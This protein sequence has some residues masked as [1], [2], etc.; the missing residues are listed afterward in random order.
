MKLRQL[1]S[2][3]AVRSLHD[4]KV[5]PYALEPHDAVHPATFGRP[6]ALQLQSQLD[7]ELRR[8][9]EVVDDDTDVLHPLD[10]HVLDGTPVSKGDPRCQR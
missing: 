8:G 2:S 9:C 10:S 7:E 5:R 6:L 4:R 3:V 1:E